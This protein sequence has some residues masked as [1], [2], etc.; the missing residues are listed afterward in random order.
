MV[1]VADHGFGHI[2]Q[3]SAV[4]NQLHR[5]APEVE[6]T[7][8]CGLNREALS[9]WFNCPFEHQQRASEFGMLMDNA[10]DVQREASLTRYRQFHSEWNK[11]LAEET[12]YIRQAKPDLVFANISYLTLAAAQQLGINNIAMCSLNWSEI[13]QGYASEAELGICQQANDI[14]NRATHFIQPEPHMPMTQL[15]NRHT[16]APLARIGNPQKSALK[17]HLNIPKKAKLLLIGMGGI[18]TDLPIEKWPIENNIYYLIPD[19]WPCNHPNA[20]HF[21]QSE[22]N[23]IDMLCSCDALITKPGYGSFSEAACN[24]I[25]VLYLRRNDWP[26]EPHLVEWLQHHGCSHELSRKDFFNG[27]FS[28]AL[29]QLTPQVMTPTPSGAEQAAT[30]ILQQLSI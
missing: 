4:I 2:S 3:S 29:Q 21:K 27:K 19:S 13:L 11:H 17:E 7:L 15:R 25:P 6:I 20:R 23:F 12:T 18:P 30:L 24:G 14:Y 26:E 28:L 16:V 8:Q 5:L 22:L 9:R 10:V 1:S